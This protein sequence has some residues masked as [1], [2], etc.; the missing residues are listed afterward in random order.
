MNAEYKLSLENRTVD[1]VEPG[2][3]DVLTNAKQNMG[4]IPNMYA[5]MANSPILLE[6]YIDGYKLFREKSG[7]SPIEQEVILLAISR[8]NGCNYCMA[9]HSSIADTMS[10]VPIEVTDAIR[11][12]TVIPDSK[13]AELASF[14]RTMVSKRG[15]PSSDEVNTFLV[16]GYNEQ[17]VL[18]IILAISVKTI[19]NY[20]NHLFHT[21]LDDVFKS[22]EW[23]EQ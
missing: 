13:L 10:K 22:R 2:A 9:A 17:C 23:H 1:N 6:S 19:S 15:L 3:K 21:K 4:F 11:N 12:D 20:A 18:E 16:E 7:F 5:A 14:T 8:E